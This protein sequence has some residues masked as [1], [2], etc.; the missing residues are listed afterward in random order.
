MPTGY[1]FCGCGGE[2]EIGRWFVLGHDITAAAALRAV[3]GE[4]LPQ[5]LVR[6]GYG[7]TAR[8]SRKPSNR[9]AGCAA[10]AARTPERRPD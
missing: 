8:S 4:T 2:A 3:Q 1:C 9:R 5:R 10:P 7:R 6:V